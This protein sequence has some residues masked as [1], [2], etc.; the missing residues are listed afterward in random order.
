MTALAFCFDG[1]VYM[2]DVKRVS[3]RAKAAL[4]REPKIL[5]V[6]CLREREQNTHF[7]L[8]E[9]IAE[10]TRQ[11][12]ARAFLIGIGHE[13]SVYYLIIRKIPFT[14]WGPYLAD[15]QLLGKEAAKEQCTACF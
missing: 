4:P 11:K 14:N 13:V 2:S 6:D 8:Q 10:I 1:I 12:A 7:C 3:E 9:A 15:S 5:F